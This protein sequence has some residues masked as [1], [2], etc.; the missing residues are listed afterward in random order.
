MGDSTELTVVEIPIR[1]RDLFDDKSAI[2][3]E[4]LLHCFFWILDGF[5][6]TSPNQ[7]QHVLVLQFFF[8]KWFYLVER[9]LG[10]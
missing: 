10:L 9:H 4:K 2:G 3:F 5:Q 8:A 6:L 1:T 7:I